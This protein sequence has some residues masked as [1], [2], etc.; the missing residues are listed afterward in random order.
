M[1]VAAMFTVLVITS[2]SPL[3]AEKT[4]PPPDDE[5]TLEE[6]AAIIKQKQAEERQREE[7]R[8][9]LQPAM[10][11]IARTNPTS[12]LELIDAINSLILLDQPDEAKKY[13]TKLLA[14][15]LN[16]EANY[17]LQRKVGSGVF[18]KLS[19][20]KRYHPE[21]QQLADVVLN[22][23]YKQ[24]HDPRRL[25]Q[26]VSQLNNPS[27]DIR[28][29]ALA[30]L[31]DAGDDA[32]LAMIAVLA[33]PRRAKEHEKVRYGLYQMGPTVVE[34]LLGTLGSGDANLMT[35]TVEVLGLLEASQAT[36]YLIHPLL[37]K[38]APEALRHASAE[39]LKRIVGAVPT[40]R[41]GQRYLARRV[42]QLTS[43]D[44]PRQADAEGN[45]ALWLWHPEQKTPVRVVHE[46]GDAA[47]VVA[48]QLAT[49]LYDLWPDNAQYRRSYL[50]AILESGKLLSGLDR[51]LPGGDGSIRQLA[52]QT[53]AAAVE[54]VLV[55]AMDEGRV[56]AAIGATEVLGDIGDGSLLL[57]EDGRE[58][59]LV[60]ALTHGN[61]RLRYAAAEAIIKMDVAHDYP[62]A[63]RLP[64]TLGYLASSAGE[65]RVLIG[66]PRTADAQ[67]L[68]GMLA[69]MG[70]QADTATTGRELFFKAAA[71][72]DYEMVLVADSIDDPPLG[73]TLQLLRKDRR[74]AWLPIG[75][76]ARGERLVPLQLQ[77]GDDPLTEA[78][79]RPHD[80]EAM[81]FQVARLLQIAGRHGITHQ[82]RVRHAS[83]ALAWLTR[84]AEEPDR[85]GFYDLLREVPNLERA[86][87]TG[88]V[89]DRAA[90]VL[91]QL[92][93]T[94]AQAALVD[95][96]SQ[97]ARPL[98][99]RQAAAAA[100]DVAT[101]KRGLML[102]EDD[103]NRQYARFNQSEQLDAGTQAVLGQILD[104]IERQLL[105]QRTGKSNDK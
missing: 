38:N 66:H 15:K 14:L 93:S 44:L 22:A 55:N 9:R 50:M 91:G 69:E 29:A 48:A 5:L 54:D 47:L 3:R 71:S 42:D 82:E 27:Q 7:D 49:D 74:T 81:E 87:M 89:P 99:D 70:F 31:R 60:D 83:A 28:V 23:A 68:V 2:A 101:R 62:G 8:R 95:F 84:L 51:S 79:P 4:L 52:A 94:S 77:V 85:Y 11:A 25:A 1:L 64:E 20:D 33:D 18:F 40:E 37:S 17:V 105:V 56:A 24:A 76:L 78:F 67:S 30:D 57:S 58:R 46:A 16:D 97:N 43:G 90:Q 21:G 13:I 92:G 100:F 73:E 10:D 45:I 88:P 53:G 80:R 19:A 102:L 34:P 98:A 75:V 65:R 36:P 12:P 72:P 61:R 6:R 59:P 104:A 86:L 39:A 26:L 32:A 41:D 96:A 63:S 35:Q 103:I